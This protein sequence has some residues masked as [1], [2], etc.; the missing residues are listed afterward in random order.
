M[1]RVHRL[2]SALVTVYG[3]DSSKYRVL[4]RASPTG[5]GRGCSRRS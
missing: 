2:S 3:Y 5:A 1:I 4:V